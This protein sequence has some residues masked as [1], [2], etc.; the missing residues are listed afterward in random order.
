M[1]E[2]SS[3]PLDGDRPRSG[4]PVFP[5]WNGPLRVCDLFS[6]VLPDYRSLA[7]TVGCDVYSVEHAPCNK[8]K[9]SVL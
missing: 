6:V 1:E 8:Y 3:C 4:S 2:S 9:W 7:L 5:I